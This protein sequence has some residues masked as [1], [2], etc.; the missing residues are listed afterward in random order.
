MQPSRLAV[1]IT[2][3]CSFAVYGVITPFL[4]IILH[5]QGLSDSE[6]TFAIIGNGLAAL[7]APLLVAHF[8]DKHFAMRRILA[9]LYLVTAATSSLWLWA[10]SLIIALLA[11]MLFFSLMIPGISMLETFT[12]QLAESGKKSWGEKAFTFQGVRAW[13]SVG[14]MCPALLLIPISKFSSVTSSVLVW[15]SAVFAAIAAVSVLFLPHNE[16][17]RGSRGAPSKEAFKVALR[18]PLRAVFE[19]TTIAGIA[20]SIFYVVYPRFLQ[21]LGNSKVNIGLIVNLGVAWE[22]A[23]MPFTSK[24]ISRFGAKN[25]VLMGILSVP[26]RLIAVALWPSTTL[27][28][29]LQFLH[30]P[31]VIGLIVAVP[32]FLAQVADPRY[33]FSLQGVNTTLVMGVARLIGPCLCSLIL[34]GYQD[35]ALGGLRM[36]LATAGILALVAAAVLLSGSRRDARQTQVDAAHTP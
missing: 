25:I 28:I 16:P 19:A 26:L 6:V 13:G 22:I 11:T 10:D 36:L 1:T 21:E 35:D 17:V 23:L 9:T 7:I 30:A 4:P 5:E 33:R 24:L 8:A 32:I 18:P 14:F 34:L 27:A 2:F 31:L 3:F 12:V 29:A 20:L 15:T